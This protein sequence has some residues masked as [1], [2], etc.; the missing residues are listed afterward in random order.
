MIAR[1]DPFFR[2]PGEQAPRVSGVGKIW[3]DN[4]A[5]IKQSGSRNFAPGAPLLAE[6]VSQ[7]EQTAQ[8]VDSQSLGPVIDAAL[9]QWQGI[10]LS[11]VIVPPSG[12]GGV[13][14][15]FGQSSAIDFLARAEDPNKA[16]E[17]YGNAGL[18]EGGFDDQLLL[19]NMVRPNYGALGQRGALSGMFSHTNLR[20]TVIRRLPPT[21][22]PFNPSLIP[23]WMEAKS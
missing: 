20:S 1:P 4:I 7:S 22:M 23:G 19:E 21:A 2:Y 5:L 17:P 13:Q 11:S 15:G 16:P 3:L 10:G 14:F 18:S 9:S 8:V 6:E 12:S